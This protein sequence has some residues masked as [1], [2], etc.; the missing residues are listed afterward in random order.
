M[1]SKQEMAARSAAE[2]FERALVLRN[3]IKA[4]GHLA[5]RQHVE[6]RREDHQDV[7]ATR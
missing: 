2:D 3:E 6:R 1:N 4:I 5:D 7:I